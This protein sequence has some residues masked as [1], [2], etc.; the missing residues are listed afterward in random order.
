MDGREIEYGVQHGSTLGP[1][2]CNI[3]LIDIFFI[4]ENE[5][6]ASYAD[7]TTPHTYARDTLTVTSEL[8]STSNWLEKNHLKA[9]PEKCHLL[10][11]SKSSIEAKIGGASVT[12]SK[13][14]TLLVKYDEDTILYLVPKTWS[15]VPQTIKEI[16]SYI[17]SK[18]K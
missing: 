14:E 9:N 11:S 7:D 6:I 4:Y 17:R 12:S 15:I 5:D 3:D 18:Q 1:L 8:Q 16:T 10:L 2:L 13:M